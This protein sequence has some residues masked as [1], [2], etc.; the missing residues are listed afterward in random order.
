MDSLFNQFQ[1]G[2]PGVMTDMGTVLAGFITFV[3][4][5]VG[6]TV[7]VKAF[8]SLTSPKDSDQ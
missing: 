5:F 2:I 8:T 7:V 1:L 3:I 4:I 6:F